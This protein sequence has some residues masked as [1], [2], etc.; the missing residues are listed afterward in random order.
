MKQV[1]P[2]FETSSLA[3]AAAVICLGIPVDSV[4]KSPD[5]KSV[6]IFNRSQYPDLD[7]IVQEFW[8]KALR[9]E[10]NAFWE[11]I[12]FLKNRIYGD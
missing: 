4:I 8:K 12:R 5:G 3:L 10:P 1:N 6:F 11:A 9:T 2:F 7:E